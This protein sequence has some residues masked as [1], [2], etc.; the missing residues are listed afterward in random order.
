VKIKLFAYSDQLFVGRVISIEPT[1]VNN[2]PLLE[3]ASE[4][5]SSCG[6][7]LVRMIIE[8]PNAEKIL[9]IGMSSYAKSQEGKMPSSSSSL[10]L[11]SVLYRS[12]FGLGFLNFSLVECGL[13]PS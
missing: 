8:I 2:S 9:K 3:H 5:T 11:Y 12:S 13:K 7:R 10:V 4:Q 6:E 1:A